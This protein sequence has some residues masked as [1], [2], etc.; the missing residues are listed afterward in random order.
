MYWDC[1]SPTP[2][3]HNIL[4]ATEAK[5]FHCLSLSFVPNY[6]LFHF[7]AYVPQNYLWYKV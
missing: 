2:P 6:S 5:K 1:K 7:V 3:V 4:S